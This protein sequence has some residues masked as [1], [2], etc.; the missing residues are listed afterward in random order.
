MTI[1]GIGLCAIL[2]ALLAQLR[3]GF[4]FAGQSYG[5]SALVPVAVLFAAVL[6]LLTA[7]VVRTLCR[8]MGWVKVR[9]V[10]A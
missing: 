8:E 9:T 1:G 6:L 3:V 5:C 4:T 2:C 7:Y 10:T